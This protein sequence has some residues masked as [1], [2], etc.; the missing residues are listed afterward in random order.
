LTAARTE[1]RRGLPSIQ[2]LGETPND[3]A[4]HERDESPGYERERGGG[5][6]L[7]LPPTN[8][9]TRCRYAAC[10]IGDATDSRHADRDDTPDAIGKGMPRLGEPSAPPP[11]RGHEDERVA[12]LERTTR[13]RCGRA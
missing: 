11:R 3:G 4:A 1:R 5:E 10:V 2:A 12:A 6:G 9:V 13:A 8:A 7:S